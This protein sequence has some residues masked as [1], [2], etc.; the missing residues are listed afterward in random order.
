MKFSAEINPPIFKPF[1]KTYLP[2]GIL[3]IACL[4]FCLLLTKRPILGLREYK[5][6]VINICG[7]HE[8]AGR[9]VL[10]F[11]RFH[12]YVEIVKKIEEKVL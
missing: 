10:V 12:R 2:G 7:I 6:K 1:R 5:L 9:E 3:A 8:T 4:T 11:D